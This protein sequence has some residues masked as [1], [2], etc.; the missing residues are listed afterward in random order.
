MLTKKSGL[1]DWH[2][3]RRRL[4]ETGF[5]H[6][7]R[8][9]LHATQAH[10]ICDDHKVHGAGVGHCRLLQDGMNGQIVGFSRRA[11]SAVCGCKKSVIEVLNIFR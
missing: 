10:Q 1:Q 5:G 3:D 11:D 4:S 8:K 6:V 9:G 7:L 2:V